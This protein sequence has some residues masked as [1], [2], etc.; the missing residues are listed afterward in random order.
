MLYLAMT[1]GAVTLQLLLLERTI[2]MT[3]VTVAMTTVT[4]AMTIAVV[5]MV[6]ETMAIMVM[7]TMV[8]N[9]YA[10]E[11]RSKSSSYEGLSP[12]EK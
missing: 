2:A 11:C 4:V 5:V 12:G 7:E 3:T 6:T 8:S 10:N 1:T 9:D